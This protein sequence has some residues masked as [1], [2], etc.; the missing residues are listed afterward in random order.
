MPAKTSIKKEEEKAQAPVKSTIE[1][2]IS[3]RGREH[4]IA[5]KVGNE[6]LPVEFKQ[7]T[8]FVDTSTALGKKISQGLRNCTVRDIRLVKPPL[9]ADQLA[10]RAEAMRTLRGLTAVHL[11]SLLTTEETRKHGAILGDGTDRDAI[12]AVILQEK[13]F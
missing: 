11:F 1:Q 12:I 10:E 9:E 6:S 7:Y 5:V 3:L 13:S 2:W 4:T 8:T